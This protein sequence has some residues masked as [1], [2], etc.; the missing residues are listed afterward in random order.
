[1]EKTTKNKNTEIV[2]FGSD[3]FSVPVFKKLIKKYNV[4]ALVCE[5]D[6]PSGR[7]QKITA[8]PTKKIAENNNI[9]IFQPQSVKKD[10]IFFEKIKALNCDLFIVAAFGQIIPLNILNLPLHGSL[11]IH[12][13][14]LPKYRGAS[15]IR[16]TLL[17]GDKKTGITIILMDQGMDTGD[18]VAQEVTTV[19][20]NDN[21]IT[22]SK[23][24]ADQ[25]A[26][27]CIRIIPGYLNGEFTLLTQDDNQA[28][29]TKK[30][31]KNDGLINWK[32]S[33]KDIKNQ[34]KA[35]IDWPGTYTK[36]KQKK[37]DLITAKVSDFDKN[38]K[39]GQVFKCKN[40]IFVQCGQG[41]LKLETVKLEG[42]KVTDIKNFIN[43]HQ[44]FIG[45][46]LG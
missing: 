28:T 34:L 44:D 30:I 36:F 24:L 8:P 13:S 26:E 16:Q 9:P 41:S 40:N 11:N 42:K 17:N 7:N 15:P 33:A 39:T 22:L 23:K 2:F 18:I 38:I 37:L 10:N 5:S 21:Y 20:K 14:L 27:F 43:G 46:V 45:S 32:Q 31:K 6:K 1:M 35:F 25:S 29:Y 12:P 4:K 3:P 19:K